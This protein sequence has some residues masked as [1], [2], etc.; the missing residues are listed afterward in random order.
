MSFFFSCDGKAEFLGSLFQYSVTHILLLS[1][2]KTVVLPNIL[3]KRSF[4]YVLFRILS[5][6][7][8]ISRF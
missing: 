7:R 6:Y 4:F 5:I 1:I 8:G 3:W 2:L